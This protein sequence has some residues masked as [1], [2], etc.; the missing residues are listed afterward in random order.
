MTNEEQRLIEASRLGDLEAFNQLVRIYEVRIYN[1]CY[2]MLGDRD[3][4]ADVAQE[5]FITAF[6]KIGHFRGNFFRAWI[7]RIATNGCYD[8]LRARKRRPTLSLS[9]HQDPDEQPFDLPD[10]GE[11]PDEFAQRRELAAAIQES[12]EQLPSDQ[13]IVV[14]LSDIQGF[15]YEEIATVTATNLGTVKSRL[16]RARSRLREILR[17]KG[18]LR[19]D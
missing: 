10:R 4:A 7:C 8:L 13:R 16:S 17:A 2:R 18:C 9:A 14:I 3:A 6:A 11:S 1:L 5:T 19:L 12:I 15:T